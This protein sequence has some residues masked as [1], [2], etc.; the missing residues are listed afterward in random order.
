[1]P[2]SNGTF[3]TFDYHYRRESDGKPFRIW[4]LTSAV[5]LYALYV[6]FG[7]TVPG[8]D[9]EIYLRGTSPSTGS[10]L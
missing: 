6:A 7:F 8:M 9:W 2:G 10:K 5:T 1:M 3:Y 4:G